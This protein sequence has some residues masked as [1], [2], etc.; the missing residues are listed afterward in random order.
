[1]SFTTPTD[2]R[3]MRWHGIQ[4]SDYPFVANAAGYGARGDGVTDDTAAIQAA[5]NAVAAAG[6]GKVILPPG[7]FVTSASLVLP[8]DN[9]WLQGA[10]YNTIIYPVN[11]ATFSVITTPLPPA[12]NTTGYQIHY[13]RVSDLQINCARMLGNVNGQGNGVHFY[14]AQ[15]FTIDN[16]F[17][18]NCLNWCFL[19]DGD[20]SNPTYNGHLTRLLT[21]VSAAGI[22]CA[23][24]ATD[25]SMNV[26]KWFDSATTS[27]QPTF[28]S[29]TAAHHLAAPSGRLYVADNVF[30][31]G[32]T[33]NSAALAFTNSSRSRILANTFDTILNNCISVS[34]SDGNVIA[35]NEFIDPAHGGGAECIHVGSNSTVVIGNR[36]EY[37]QTIENTYAVQEHGAYTGN[38]Y[39]GNTFPAGT[40][41]IFS[42]NA[43]GT[44]ICRDNVGYNP[45]GHAVTQPAVPASGTAQTNFSGADCTVYVTGGTVSAVA[46]GGTAT[47][48]TSGPFRV[49]AG[50]TITLT[51]SAAPTWQWFGD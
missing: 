13:V 21:D 47:G 23:S 17:V 15:W 22:Y 31:G 16:V 2:L 20:T 33:Q 28:G 1:M 35:F 5:L 48:L 26:L 14:G 10:G 51:Y 37:F 6:G 50:Q 39:Y 27:Q 42:L 25:I 41:G 45:R 38:V 4:G 36:I 8:G 9:V 12:L 11:G 40:T 24:E 3:D 18:I 46:I 43:G 32:G 30:G 19:L 34:G 29:S 49:A 7:K 44:S